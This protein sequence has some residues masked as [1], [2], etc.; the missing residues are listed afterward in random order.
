MKALPVDADKK[1]FQDYIEKEFKKIYLDGF[2]NGMK[3][4]GDIVVST[5]KDC[6]DDNY[7]EKIA[8]VLKFCESKKQEVK[9]KEN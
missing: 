1:K 8:I 6:T 9:N 5:L 3:T 2:T 4:I 7:K